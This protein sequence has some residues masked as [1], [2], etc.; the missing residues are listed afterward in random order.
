VLGRDE[1]T[2]QDFED[3]ERVI[4]AMVLSLTGRGDKHA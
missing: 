4:T 3:A 1:L 2:S